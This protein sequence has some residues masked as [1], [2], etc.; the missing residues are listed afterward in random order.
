MQQ[1]DFAP[2][3]QFHGFVVDQVDDLPD[4]NATMVRLS[5]G[6]TGARFMHLVRDCMDTI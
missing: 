1:H 4:V 6:K 5:H 3:Q 2:G